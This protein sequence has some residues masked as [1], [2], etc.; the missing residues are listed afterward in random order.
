MVLRVAG[1]VLKEN[2]L[3]PFTKSDIRINARERSITVTR[4]PKKRA[5]GTY[6][7]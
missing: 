5:K 3:H 4:E 7:D 1:V 6:N 2:V